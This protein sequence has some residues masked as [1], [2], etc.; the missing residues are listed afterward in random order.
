MTAR[1]GRRS[2]PWLLAFA[3]YSA[4]TL[5]ITW[6]LARHLTSVLPHDSGDPLLNAW[7]LWWNAQALPLTDRWLNAP[8]FWPMK[9]AIV[10]SEHLLGLS[11][12]ATPLQWLGAGPVTAYNVVF[13]L[14]F[15]LSAIAAHALGHVLTGRH[16]AAAIAGLAFAF[17]PYRTSQLAHI[18]ILWAFWMPLALLALHRYAASGN[19][20]WLVLFAAMWIGEGLSNGYFELFFPLLLGLWTLWFLVSAGEWRKTVAVAAAFCAGSIALLPVAIPYL[21]LHEQLALERRYQEV[22]VFSA[23][24]SSL[25]APPPLALA[26]TLLP[27][28]GNAEQQLFP[29]FT[30]AGLVALAALAS[31][32]WRDGESPGRRRLTLVLAALAGVFVAVS[33]VAASGRPWALRAGGLTIVS[34]TTAMKPLTAAIWCGIFALAASAPFARALRARSAFAFY[35]CAAAAMYVLSFGPQPSFFGT[36]FWY[37]PPYAWLMELPGFVN[38]RA[39]ARF[40]ALAE[41]C[42]AIAAALA[43]VRLRDHLPRRF[44]VALATVALAGALVDGWIRALPLAS[45]PERF[46]S[47]EQADAAAVVEV[48]VD[49][50]VAGIAALYRSIYHRRPTVNGYSGF[51]PIYYS[52]LRAA[53][54]ADGEDAFDGIAPHGPL[55][56]VDATGRIV[57]TRPG[58]PGEPPPAGQPLPIHAVT[59]EPVPIDLALVRDGSERTRWDSGSPQEGSETITIDL[60]SASSVNGVRLAIGPY[61][62]DF[63]RLLTVDV[64]DDLHAWTTRWSGLCGAKTVAAAVDDARLVPLTVTFPSAQARYIRLRQL[65]ADAVYHWSIAELSVFG[66]TSHQLAAATGVGSRSPGPV[67]SRRP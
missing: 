23:D 53:L 12:V 35:V 28:T 32:R 52:V 64:S 4:L 31:V 42:L 29:G 19:A 6:P 41:M 33:L 45:L 47:L 39:P 59:A 24:L 63:P 30:I 14:S 54:D 61:Y 66:T 49:S 17:N 43:L 37:R 22:V 46:A 1:G 7:I 10:L 20:R 27:A 67:G 8:M 55:T 58:R 51:L 36:P 15:P 26:S 9:G 16:D 5:V 34:V 65:G 38:V 18:Q 2:T 60:G 25:A 48:P 3:A 57:G 44:A 62:A 13:L 40:A 50:M 11:L 56:F 21:R